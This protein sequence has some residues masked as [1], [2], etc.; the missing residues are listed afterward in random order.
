MKMRKL[1]LMLSLICSF[2]LF[3]ASKNSMTIFEEKFDKETVGF[4]LTNDDGVNAAVFADS[5]KAE[6]NVLVYDESETEQIKKMAFESKVL[7]KSVTSR[8]Q[9]EAR[10]IYQEIVKKFKAF[11]P[12]AKNDYDFFGD[13]GFVRVSYFITQDASISNRDRL[14]IQSTTEKIL[15][16]LLDSTP[17]SSTSKPSSSKT[18]EE[19]AKLIVWSFT[20]E[21]ETYLSEYDYGYGDT[22]PNVEVGYSLIPTDQFP[23]SLDSAFARGDG[24]DVFALEEAFVRRYVESGMLLPLD[25]LYEEVKDKMED[26]PIKIGSYDGHVYAMSWGMYPGAMFYRRSLAKKY[27]GTDDPEEIQKLFSDEDK[28][29]ETARLLKERS[30]GKCR[31]VSALGDLYRPF[32]GMRRK[33]WVVDGELYLDPAMEKYMDVCKIMHDEELDADA[34]QWSEAWFAG[35]EDWLRDEDGNRLE[36][37]SYFMPYWGLKWVLELNAP[38]TSGDWAMCA[39]PSGWYWGGTWIAANKNTK[40]PNAA[41][42]M[43]RYLTTDEYFLE[44]MAM[45]SGE[46]VGNIKVQD[47]IKDDFDEPF[48]GGQNYYDEF[49]EYAKN[50]DGTLYQSSDNEIYMYFM[51]AV[52]SY[53][54][55]DSSK[56][57]ALEEF[58]HEVRNRLGF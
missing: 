24:P 31:L 20:D 48:L 28:M 52:T 36:I 27:L 35:M 38:E 55:E 57:E 51:E 21:L 43:I 25:D 9:Y 13:Y 3:A 56:E 17:A 1:F 37:F 40:N 50:V 45:S 2:N 5:M 19:N 42:E 30:N 58:R 16:L 15:K 34:G 22:H 14:G 53:Y 23:T 32:L 39:G 41:K 54:Y 6:V 46:L 29:L 18:S 33:P 49:C 10:N 8:D 7:V 44:G 4:Y 12:I 11:T 47:K 26:F